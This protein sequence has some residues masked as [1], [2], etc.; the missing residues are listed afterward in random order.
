MNFLFFLTVAN[1]L[2]TIRLLTVMVPLACVEAGVVVGEMGATPG[3]ADALRISIG[4][5]EQNQRV[6]ASLAVAR[7]AA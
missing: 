6:L 5:P 2:A 1:G 3:L 4:T 7:Q